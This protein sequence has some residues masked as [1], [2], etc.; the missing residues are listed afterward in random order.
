MHWAARSISEYKFWPVTVFGTLTASPEQHGRLDLRAHILARENNQDFD[1]IS[2]IERFGYRSSAFGEE[3]TKWIKRIRETGPNGRVPVRY[4]VVAEMHD[5]DRTS[6]EMRYRPHFHIMLHDCSAKLI[7]GSP[8]EAFTAGQ[9]GEWRRVKD[10]KGA[11]HVYVT[12]D[13]FIRKE[14]KLGFSK[15][16]FAED[17]KAA[18]Y[19]CKYIAKTMQ[20]RVRASKSYGDPESVGAPRSEG[21]PSAEARRARMLLNTADKSLVPSIV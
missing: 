20:S 8:L 3:V 11:R 13:A 16:Q 10:L 1:C 18:F 14:W 6:P 9:D 2:E 17:S 19:V 7:Q 21:Q 5:G 12:D 15:F 4:L